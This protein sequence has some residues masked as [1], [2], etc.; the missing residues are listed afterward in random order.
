MSLL[1]TLGR[2]VSLMAMVGCIRQA[3]NGSQQQQHTSSD[4]M[5]HLFYLAGAFCG[6]SRVFLSFISDLQV[7]AFLG[8]KQKK[9]GERAGR[10]I[11]DLGWWS[12]DGMGCK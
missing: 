1:C 8:Q 6:F 4:R 9:W 7:V 5:R 12:Y 3:P 11:L 2:D 10:V